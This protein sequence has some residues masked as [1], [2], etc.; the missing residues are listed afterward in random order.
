MWQAERT[1]DML[2]ARHPDVEI[3]IVR[4]HSQGDQKQHQSISDLGTVGI[5]TREIERALQDDR[6]DVAV[7]SL[8]DLPT[9]SPAGLRLAAHLPRD[10]PRDALVAKALQGFAAEEPA[11]A[12]AALPRAATLGTSSLRRRAELVRARPDLQVVPVRGNVPTRLAKVEEGQLDGV[13]LSHAGLARLGLRPPGC[14]LLDPDIMMPAPAQGTIAVQVREDDTG[15][16]EL[17]SSIDDPVTR[18]TTTTER[19][20]LQELRGGCR[21]P[22]GA[23]ARLED[24]TLILRARL[25]SADGRA[26]LECTDSGPAS[27]PDELAHRVADDLRAQGAA[28]ILADLRDEPQA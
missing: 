1:R 13:L 26:V 4:I 18:L 28:K 22:L 21:V 17:A 25:L 27:A 3:E 6:V 16:H 15:T 5:F 23:L 9:E 2:R 11:L 7:H 14:V 19:L 24:E 10:D 8:K 20:L 12:L